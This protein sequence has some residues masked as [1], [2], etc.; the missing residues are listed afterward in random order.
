MTARAGDA[1]SHVYF[2]PPQAAFSGAIFRQINDRDLGHPQRARTGSVG[3]NLIYSARICMAP[4]S[5]GTPRIWFQPFTCASL[6]SNC[7][8]FIQWCFQVLNWLKN[9]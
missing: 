1:L 2:R 6:V 3:C 9:R 4:C 7:E 8:D 5:G